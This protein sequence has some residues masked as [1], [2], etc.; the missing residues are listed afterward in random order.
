M[1]EGALSAGV[2]PPVGH[3]Q[4]RPRV[5]AGWPRHNVTS[6]IGQE[7]AVVTLPRCAAPNVT[8]GPPSW[9]PDVT[10]WRRR[11]NGA[12]RRPRPPASPGAPALPPPARPPGPP[13]L[14]EVVERDRAQPG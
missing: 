6:A 2:E 12:R 9:T 1:C 11:Q 13:G 5:V 10:L 8:T 3:T 4:R 7:A 14:S